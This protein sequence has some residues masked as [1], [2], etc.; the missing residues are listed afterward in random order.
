MWEL[1]SRPTGCVTEVCLWSYL[2]CRVRL[3]QS[4]LV[5]QVIDWDVFLS[6]Q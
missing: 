6:R 3:L 1:R 2:L 5:L 4:L